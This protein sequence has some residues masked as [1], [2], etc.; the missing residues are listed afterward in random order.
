MNHSGA[1]LQGQHDPTDPSL[2]YQGVNLGWLLTEE[3]RPLALGLLA[4]GLGGWG[5]PMPPEKPLENFRDLPTSGEGERFQ[6]EVLT[7]TH[8]CLLP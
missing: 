8:C 1:A 3:Q 6:R 5:G 2:Q 4:A 7:S